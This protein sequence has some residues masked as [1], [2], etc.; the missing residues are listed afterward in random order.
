MARAGGRYKTEKGKDPVF[1]IG[2]KDHPDGNKPRPATNQPTAAPV[3]KSKP[4][5]EVKEDGGVKV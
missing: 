3:A 4:K 1:V 5:K 2:T